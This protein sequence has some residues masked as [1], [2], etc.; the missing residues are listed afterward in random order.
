MRFSGAFNSILEVAPL[1]RQKARYRIDA[2]RHTRTNVRCAT[3][4]QF[5]LIPRNIVAS[6]AL[7]F[8]SPAHSGHRDLGKRDQARELLAPVYGWFTEGFDTRDLKEA[9]ALLD[10]LAS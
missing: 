9:R 4:A 2:V 10:E 6:T 1:R 3:R 7:L 5:V 8:L